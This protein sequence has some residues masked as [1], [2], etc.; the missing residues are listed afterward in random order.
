MSDWLKVIILG[1]I[2]GI[3]EFLPISSTGHLIVATAL[4]DFRPEL[5]GTFEI[6]I[7]V[8]AVVAVLLYYAGEFIRHV[9]TFSSDA[10]VRRLWLS[11]IVASVPAMGVGFL[12]GDF[13]EATLFNPT[14][15]AL[16]LIAGGIAFL[17]V[18]RYFQ[19]PAG[20][21]MPPTPVIT[22]RQAL[23]IGACQMLALIPGMSRS[24]MSILGGM[25]AG[26]NRQVA[27]RFSFYMALPVLG[28]ATAYA[29]LRRISD[30]SSEDMA[31]LLLG[32][33]VSGVVAWLVIAWL[34]RYVARHTFVAFGY[35]RIV[36]GIVILLLAAAGVL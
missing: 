13:L 15:V 21:E 12:L 18:E 30:L 14:V 23:I 17:V 35:Y 6:F 26:L 16:A 24:G 11:V 8:G 28:G 2:E 34:L 31:Y 4:L 19:F 25:A 33:V 5:L 36:A 9:R 10:S 3:T 29:L 22:L 32:A 27:T 1:V 7:Q 20:G